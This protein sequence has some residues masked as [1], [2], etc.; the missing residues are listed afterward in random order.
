[1]TNE[2]TVNVKTLE[3]SFIEKIDREM[4]KNVDMVEHGIQSA[5][6]TAIDSI[7]APKTELAVR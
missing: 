1:M 2:S 6:S 7:V 3:R 5:F 4:S